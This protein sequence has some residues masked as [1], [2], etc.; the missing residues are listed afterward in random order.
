M[1]AL[2]PEP[3]HYQIEIAHREGNT[4]AAERADLIYQVLSLDSASPGTSTPEIP[5][6]IWT[7]LKDAKT[8]RRLSDHHRIVWIA[9]LDQDLL[10]EDAWRNWLF[11]IATRTDEVPTAEESSSATQRAPSDQLI[12]ICD[13]DC[14]GAVRQLVG[15][16]NYRMIDPEKGSG[17]FLNQI[18]ISLIYFHVPEKAAYDV[19]A[20]IQ[21]FMARSA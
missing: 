10:Q 9:L 20:R 18:L 12:P 16:L 1:S 11:E 7:T 5:V 21:A 6:R 14:E 15:T 17:S 13:P 19:C 8:V 3:L 2:F 4:L